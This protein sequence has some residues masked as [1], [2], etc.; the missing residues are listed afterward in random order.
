MSTALLII[1]WAVVAV[2]AA[3]RLT[4]GPRGRLAYRLAQ[5]RQRPA[6]RRAAQARD[7]A[8]PAVP[9]QQPPGPV[10]LL[11]EPCG[12]VFYF[13]RVRVDRCPADMR[14]YEHARQERILTAYERD[15]RGQR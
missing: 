10:T 11:T 3:D 1:T 5:R 14:R 12:C 15:F 9:P 6:M 4:A 13:S 8:R 2:L 7:A